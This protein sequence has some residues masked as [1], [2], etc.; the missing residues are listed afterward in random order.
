MP[1]LSEIE[2]RPNDILLEDVSD[3]AIEGLRL[4]AAALNRPFSDYVP[5]LIAS[6]F[7]TPRERLASATVI[8][9]SPE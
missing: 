3:A 6:H 4:T 1:K 5:D 8:V 7:G 9:L 2:L